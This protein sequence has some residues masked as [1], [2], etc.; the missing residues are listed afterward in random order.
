MTIN[1]LQPFQV[2]VQAPLTLLQ[3]QTL[4]QFY[5]P[6]VGAPAISLYLTFANQSV[7]E[8]YRNHRTLHTRLIETLNIDIVT[9]TEA[10]HYLEAV[11]LLRT[12]REKLPHVD[13]ERQTLLYDVQL[14][15]EVHQFARHPLL[16]T[17][18]F[19]KIGDQN[20]YQLL[21]QW[22]VEPL[23][24]AHY[25]EVTV[26][27]NECFKYPSDDLVRNVSESVATRQFRHQFVDE[28]LQI[29][30][31]TFDFAMFFKYLTAEGVDSAQFT[32]ALKHEVLAVH[33]V[34][35]LDEMQM[36]QIVLL[37]INDVTD[38]IQLDELKRIAAKK[39][40]MSKKRQPTSSDSTAFPRHYTVDELE[41]RKQ[42]LQQHLPNLSQGELGILLLCEQLPHDQFLT[43]TKATK[44]GFATDSEQFFVKD[45]A[46]KCE[47]PP[48]VVNLL[49]YHLL[50]WQGRASLFKGE[51]QRVANEWQQQQ[52]LT[53]EQTFQYLRQK[54]AE[55]AKRA[56]EVKVPRNYQPRAR[57]EEKLPQW[58]LEQ[59]N[60]KETES[61][62]LSEDLE[63]AREEV[64]R[65]L[66]Q[67]FNKGGNP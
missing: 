3:T 9:L 47:L 20:Y 17:T 14:P 6:L 44:G 23:D 38:Q 16:S 62:E 36:M 22:E 57:R 49:M 26:A 15:L 18:L 54:D 4:L 40:F 61:P 12:Y 43:K 28:E 30:S 46:S 37:A 39:Q 65:K 59:A 25:R 24:T 51:L 55:T 8:T 52:L 60:S 13:A 32:Y 19:S 35:G 5:Q 64:Q 10:R 1:P 63:K 48:A 27:F 11:G 50:I 21:K 45:L 2:R 31:A 7:D 53:L 29:E 67:L 33:E 42:E 56:Q 66:D 34:Y 58:M 41:A